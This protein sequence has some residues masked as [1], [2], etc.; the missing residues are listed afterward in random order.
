MTRIAIGIQVIT[1]LVAV[2][3]VSPAGTLYV[4]GQYATIEA[5]LAVAVA[6][7]VIEVAAGTYPEHDLAMVSGVTLR[8]ATGDPV[9]VIIDGENVDRV[10]SCMSVNA[11][12]RIEDL[13]IMHGTA[14]AGSGGGGIFF[15]AT[16]MTM[17][18]CIFRENVAQGGAAVY[19]YGSDAT[20][21][22]CVF[23]RNSDL[24]YGGTVAVYD[25]QPHFVNCT[26]CG[27]TTNGGGSVTIFDGSSIFDNCIIA[28]D[29]T[30]Y[31]VERAAGTSTFSNCDVY[32]NYQGEWLGTTSQHGIN[33][34]FSQDP[35]FCWGDPDEHWSWGIQSDS[36]CAA[37]HSGVGLIGA[38]DVDCTDVA[39]TSFSW[40]R[41]KTL[42]R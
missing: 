12:T 39:V 36:P 8:G 5:A 20:L 2:S 31:G 3:G 6:D 19:L 17:S 25:H 28:Y 34:N 26:I 30:G 42:Y 21:E 1:F 24:V 13:T 16:A 38:R 18:N 22:N 40:G 9:D 29:D 11:Q 23:S 41:V 33:G 27:N 37:A 15:Y 7:D 35:E 4:P 14:P 10:L 32:G